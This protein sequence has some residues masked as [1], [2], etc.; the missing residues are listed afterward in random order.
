[1]INDNQIKLFPISADSIKV[2]VINFI[3]SKINGFYSVTESENSYY[4]WVLTSSGDCQLGYTDIDTFH[5]DCE[6]LAK[7]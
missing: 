3:K 7:I 1:M 2:E 5:N 6:K 4:I